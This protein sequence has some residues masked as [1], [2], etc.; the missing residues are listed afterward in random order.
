MPKLRRLARGQGDANE[1]HGRPRK[2]VDVAQKLGWRGRPDKRQCFAV[3][4]RIFQLTEVRGVS[5]RRPHWRGARCAN[6]MPPT[7][8]TRATAWKG[9]NGSPNRATAMMAENKGTRLMKMPLRPGPIRSTLR[10]RK[11]WARQEG[12]IAT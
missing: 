1:R 2:D 12:K 6:R 9:A 8:S 11:I 10:N 7:T 3:A 4:V 5:T